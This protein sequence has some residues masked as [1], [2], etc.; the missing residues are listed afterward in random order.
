MYVYARGIILLKNFYSVVIF[1]S[2]FY[3]GNRTNY[4]RVR[5]A[6]ESI[7]NSVETEETRL[8]S[9]VESSVSSKLASTI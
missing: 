3:Q 6:E 7:P 2:C 8:K 1:S 4:N 9:E 5:E